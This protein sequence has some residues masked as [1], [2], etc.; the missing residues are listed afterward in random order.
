MELTQTFTD[1]YALFSGT[2]QLAGVY[3]VNVLVHANAAALPPRSIA[4][5]LAAT[6]LCRCISTLLYIVSFVN[7]LH[8]T[9]QLTLTYHACNASELAFPCHASAAAA[10]S[11]RPV[12]TRR[13]L[14]AGA[15]PLPPAPAPA[16]V[17]RVTVDEPSTK[18]VRKM[19]LALLNMPSFSDTTMN[20]ES[21]KC[22]RIMWPMLAVWLKSSAASTCTSAAVWYAA[23]RSRRA[24]EC[25]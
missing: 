24:H 4:T 10:F 16:P 3:I 18:R 15:R 6:C 8:P 19:T 9:T 11:C 14:A 13:A 23:Q 2:T 5:K 22:W 7:T 20:C 25:G 12:P 21:L 17:V 1:V